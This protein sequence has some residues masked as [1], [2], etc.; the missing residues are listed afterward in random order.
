MNDVEVS[1]TTVELTHATQPGSAGRPNE[2][3]VACGPDWIAVFDGGVALPHAHLDPLVIA[4]DCTPKPAH[5][6]YV[7]L[8]TPLH[9]ADYESSEIV[10]ACSVKTRHLRRF[11]ANQR[12]ACLPGRSAHA[13]NHLFHHACVHFPHRQIVEEK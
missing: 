10:F 9:R 2:D 1:I 8:L 5:A 3:Y 11:A 6:T 12:A 13:F 4:K 7:E